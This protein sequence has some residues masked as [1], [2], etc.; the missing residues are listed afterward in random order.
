MS[1]LLYFKGLS[2]DQ[3]FL[4]CSITHAA[5]SVLFLVCLAK[6]LNTNLKDYPQ[7]EYQELLSHSNAMTLDGAASEIR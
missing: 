4:K 3:R 2:A 1:S 5:V 7:Y 6:F